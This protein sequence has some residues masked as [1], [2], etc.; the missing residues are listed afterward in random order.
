QG[1]EPAI[2]E[3]DPRRRCFRCNRPGHFAVDCRVTLPPRTV[4]P[5]PYPPHNAYVNH[6]HV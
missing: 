1:T 5:N 6:G 2:H 4:Y 3:A